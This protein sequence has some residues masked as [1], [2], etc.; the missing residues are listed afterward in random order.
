VSGTFGSSQLQ[1]SPTPPWRRGRRFRRILVLAVLLLLAATAVLWF[2][3]VRN[4]VLVVY[5]Q[6][7]CLRHV[8]PPSTVVH[9]Y[10]PFDEGERTGVRRVP[11]EWSYLYGALS[12]PGLRSEGTPFLHELRT[13]SGKRRLVAVDVTEKPTPNSKYLTLAWRVIEPAGSP[14]VLPRILRSS[15]SRLPVDVDSGSFRVLSGDLDSNDRSHFSFVCEY[16]G[17]QQVL[18]G[19]LRDDDSVAIELRPA[20][21]VTPPAPASPASLPTSGG[22]GR[23]RGGWPFRVSRSSGPPASRPASSR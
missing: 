20:P 17:R 14:L 18:D 2:P 21:P 5:W 7:K 4:D 13:P 23:R 19:W 1:Y 22:S 6:H 3:R 16:A 12:P 8:V 15:G 10:P 9:A 11:R